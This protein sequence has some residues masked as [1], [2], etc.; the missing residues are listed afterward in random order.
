MNK[1]IAAL[2]FAAVVIA[3]P[4]FA[5]SFDPDIGTGNIVRVPQAAAPAPHLRLDLGARGAFAQVPGGAPAAASPHRS[6]GA[7]GVP[8]EYRWPVY[9]GDG[10]LTNDTW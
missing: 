4:A 3:S 5:Q 8:S 6:G 7:T 1:L 10:R 2:A 9:D